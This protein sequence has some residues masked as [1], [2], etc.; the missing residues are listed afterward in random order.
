[1]LWP[2]HSLALLWGM[3]IVG[4]GQS[5]SLSCQILIEGDSATH[6]DIDC[7]ATN[8][9][10]TPIVLTAVRFPGQELE[11]TDRVPLPG[12]NLAVDL[13]PHSMWLT[14]PSGV[15]RWQIRYRLAGDLH[16]IP[17]PVPDGSWESNIRIRVAMEGRT[18]SEP[19]FPPLTPNG[20][21]LEGEFSHLP[22]FVY[23]PLVGPESSARWLSIQSWIDL[24]IVLLTLACS[25]YWLHLRR[26]AQA[27]LKES[28]RLEPEEG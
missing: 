6:V 27:E 17:I 11:I 25:A 19:T 24:S 12:S 15:N 21:W 26:R 4:L 14:L 2:Y 16:R 3:S 22:G 5:S 1:M 8:P 9:P 13:R 20:D 28:T 7:E 23:L 18:L 10:A